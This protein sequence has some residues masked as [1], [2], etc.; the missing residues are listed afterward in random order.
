MT[1]DRTD[2]ESSIERA[3]KDCSNWGRWARTTSSGTLN[4]LDEAKRREGASLSGGVSASPL[5]ALR[6]QRPA[7]GLAAAHQPR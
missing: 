4:F 3:A 5:P 2:P 7:E 6:H 1:L